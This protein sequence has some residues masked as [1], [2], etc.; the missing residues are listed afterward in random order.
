MSVTAR[1]FKAIADG[2]GHYYPQSVVRRV[3][4]QRGRCEQVQSLAKKYADILTH[5]MAARGDI[6]QIAD[7]RK[8]SE[9][10]WLTKTYHRCNG[11]PNKIPDGYAL[12]L[13]FRDPHSIDIA[14]RIFTAGR[15]T[16]PFHAKCDSVQ[17]TDFQDNYEFPSALTGRVGLNIRL[18]HA[19]T[20][21]AFEIQVVHEE[22]LPIECK[23]HPFYKMLD[24]IRS[25]AKL[26]G[27][28]MDE[29]ERKITRFLADYTRALYDA[30]SWKYDLMKLRSAAVRPINQTQDAAQLAAAQ[31]EEAAHFI[32]NEYKY[33]KLDPIF[34]TDT[35]YMIDSVTADI[36]EATIAAPVQSVEPHR[37]QL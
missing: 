1:H 35:A 36:K 15:H 7:E 2:N 27:R 31:R 10:S 12:R 30:A 23:T 9:S 5:E 26:Q 33:K 29:D 13:T 14:R 24:H 8:K 18:R 34:L 37:L 16:H 6:V 21:G 11:D 25:N 28:D 32:L 20:S 3:D 4:F 19:K 17:M 22:M